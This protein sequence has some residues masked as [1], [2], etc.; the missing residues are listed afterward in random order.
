MLNLR[1]LIQFYTTTLQCATATL[2]CLQQSSKVNMANMCVKF[3]IAVRMPYD[4]IIILNSPETHKM[5]KKQ[6]LDNYEP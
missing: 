5:N 1:N 4:K 2:S 6:A 3:A